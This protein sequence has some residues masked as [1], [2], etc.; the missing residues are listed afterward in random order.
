M[1][2]KN[3][4]KTQSRKIAKENDFNVEFINRDFDYSEQTGVEQSCIIKGIGDCEFYQIDLEET[5][6]YTVFDSYF[7]EISEASPVEFCRNLVRE[8]I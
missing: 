5:G 7:D 4:Q 1:K 8:F 3:Y 2:F 6:K